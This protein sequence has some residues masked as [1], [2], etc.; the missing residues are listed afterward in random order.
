MINFIIYEDEKK[1]RDLYI[2][3]ILKLVG[4][5]KV[6]YQIIEIPRYTQDTLDKIQSLIGKNIFIF[7]IEVPGK[8]GLDLARE[9]RN[10]G[11]W[12]SP[13]IMITT[14]EQLK[15]TAFTS[16]ILMLDFIS[17]FYDCENSL[18]ETL[19]LSLDIIR[20]HKSLNFQCNGELYQI[21]YEDILFIEKN[22]EDLYSTIVTRNE[23]IKIKQMIGTIEEALAD[24]KRFF[25]TH[26][27][28]IINIDNLTSIELSACIMHFENIETPL[29]SR[30]KKR[31][32][33]LILGRKPPK[34]PKKKLEEVKC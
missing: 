1:F 32:L 34:S 31:E 19:K 12:K 8:T 28:C 18:K 9:I 10:N 7:D 21:P 33:K 24:D 15:S 23:K 27:S 20:S 13:M 14:H 2:S 25:R 17:K 4:S 29:L 6:A 22:L 30:D 16:K 11:D 3:I 26:R 5:M